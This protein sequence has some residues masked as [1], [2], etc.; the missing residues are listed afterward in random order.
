MN[1]N[2]RL[3]LRQATVAAMR[4]FES[5]H[6]LEEYAQYHGTSAELLRDTKLIPDT[7]FAVDTAPRY[8]IGG[9]TICVQIS[10]GPTF[11]LYD[12]SAGKQVRSIP[13]KGADPDK[14]AAAAEAFAAFKKKYTDYY[15]DRVLRLKKRNLSGAAVSPEIWKSVYLRDTAM[16]LAMAGIVW[17]DEAGQT[18]CVRSEGPVNVE[19]QPYA[20]QGAVHIAHTLELPEASIAAWQRALSWESGNSDPD[21]TLI[22]EP[23][24]HADTSSLP[25]AFSGIVITNE[26]WNAF[27][28][29]L[30]QR[31]MYVRSKYAEMDMDALPPGTS[32]P[33]DST[34]YLGNSVH[35][36]HSP[37]GYDGVM[38][39]KMELCENAGEREVNAVLTEL[40][41]S[42]IRSA[43]ASQEPELLRTEYLKAFYPGQIRWFIE[44][45][46]SA[47]STACT[48]VLMNYQNEYFPD[49]EGERP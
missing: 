13:K 28:R 41:A 18:F 42:V 12:E 8:D 34:V 19:L 15:K 30:R 9:K 16:R 20:P 3:R 11:C 35:L 31:G 22:W 2:I 38:L 7:D 23:A 25:T 48:A 27:V 44:M 1:R 40:C 36:D 14:A 39:G 26:E 21:F 43:I 47:N 37:A 29:N 32:L 49:H 33:A 5:K 24:F 46:I 4:F 45:A 10:A 6:H 17:M